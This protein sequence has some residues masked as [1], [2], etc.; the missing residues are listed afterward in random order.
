MCANLVE[1]GS[2]CG[3][4]GSA[5]RILTFVYYFAPLLVCMDCAARIA[6]CPICRQHLA[7]AARSVLSAIC[8]QLVLLRAAV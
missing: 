1:G 6:R 5:Q 4:V 8:R 2:Y 3:L 7:H